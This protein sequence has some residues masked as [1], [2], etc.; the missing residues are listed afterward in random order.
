MAEDHEVFNPKEFREV[1]L[2][3]REIP[4]STGPVT[5]VD[6]NR[7]EKGKFYENSLDAPTTHFRNTLKDAF[8]N[9]TTLIC[10]VTP[11]GLVRYSVSPHVNHFLLDSKY[12]RDG[13]APGFYNGERVNPLILE[14]PIKSPTATDVEKV[15]TFFLSAF[16]KDVPGAQL[17]IVWP[18]GNIE[19]TGRKK[20]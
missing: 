11:E 10:L 14:V 8:L 5:E 15:K 13:S 7:D 17:I 3:G 6:L 4:L 16:P 2:T 20:Y 12:E 18:E 9:K 19:Y 1:Q